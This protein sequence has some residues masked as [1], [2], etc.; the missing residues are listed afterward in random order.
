MS[1]RVRYQHC[2]I[3]LKFSTCEL[4]CLEQENAC[5]RCMLKAC[6]CCLWCLEKCLAY[7]NQVSHVMSMRKEN[8]VARTRETTSSVLTAH[9]SEWLGCR[10][11][12]LQQRSTAP[13]SAPLPVMLSSSW[14]RM[15]FEWQLSTLWATLCSSWERYHTDT[16][17]ELTAN[18]WNPSVFVILPLISILPGAYSRLHSFCRRP[19]SQLPEGLHGL[20]PASPH[21]VSVCLPGGSLL[22]FC[23]WKRGRRSLPLLRC[24]HKV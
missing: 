8:W 18:Q 23:L 3:H 12:T 22:P 21:C 4:L 14:W 15:L 17:C 24:G 13:V 1:C 11:L 6:V 20:G 5:A 16:L 19:G 2:L 9:V 10:M 7:L